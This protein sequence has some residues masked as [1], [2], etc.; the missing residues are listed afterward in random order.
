MGMF[1]WPF[2]IATLGCQRVLISPQSSPFLQVVFQPFP[3]M[4][5]KNDIAF[6]HITMIIIVYHSLSQY[7]H[8]IPRLLI[9]SQGYPSIIPSFYLYLP[10]ILSHRQ[11]SQF[12]KAMPAAISV[13]PDGLDPRMTMVIF[14]VH[15]EKR[16]SFMVILW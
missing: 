7:T 5:G 9:L 3:V 12:S 11:S 1:L 8:I 10:I 14:A 13:R 15:H 4:G 6:S 2:S 16:G